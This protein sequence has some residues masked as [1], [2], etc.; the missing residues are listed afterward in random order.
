[1]VET[2]EEINKE[3]QVV[4]TNL[5]FLLEANT[6]GIINWIRRN[7]NDEAIHDMFPTVW[8]LLQERIHKHQHEAREVDEGDG[9]LPIHNVLY[10]SVGRKELTAAPLSLLQL[11]IQ[12]HSD[13]LHFQD[14]LGRIPLHWA[15]G[16]PSID[17]FRAVLYND[18]AEATT[19]QTSNG[20]IPLHWSTD[21]NISLA[22]LWEL[23]CFNRDCVTI[24]DGRGMT[25]MELLRGKYEPWYRQ[26]LPTRQNA[27]AVLLKL[28][29]NYNHVPK[30]PMD[31]DDVTALIESHPACTVLA[32]RLEHGDDTFILHQALEA[33]CPFVLVKALVEVFPNQLQQQCTTGCLPLHIALQSNLGASVRLLASAYPV[34]M[35]IADPFNGLLPIEQ[36]LLN[37]VNDGSLDNMDAVNALLRANPAFLSRIE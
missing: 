5:L 36:A 10:L 6:D 34:A 26:V 13:G 19:I 2:I 30:L 17:C 18:N 35:Y 31:D 20:W 22:R 23:L 7:Y 14:G 1:M 27:K 3:I 37:A 32:Q 16:H 28:A 9:S 4:P 24:Q 21:P 29:A 8:S 15:V 11:L 12:L 25:A 33:M